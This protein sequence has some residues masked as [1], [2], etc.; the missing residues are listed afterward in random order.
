[1]ECI[2]Q[3]LIA[4]GICMCLVSKT[5]SFISCELSEKFDETE[6]VYRFELNKRFCVCLK[7]F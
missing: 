6:S 3:D 2:F 5:K 7:K 4:R 1:M